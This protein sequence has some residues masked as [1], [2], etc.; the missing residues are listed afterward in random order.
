MAAA[1]TDQSGI[2]YRALFV[3]AEA[4]HLAGDERQALEM[5]EEAAAQAPTAELARRA[6][7]SRLM[8]LTELESDQAAHALQA[9]SSGVPADDPHELVLEA[10]RRLGVELK[11]G[12]LRSLQRARDAAQLVPYVPDVLVRIS[13]R[14]VLAAALTTSSEYLEALR[15]ARDM[16][17]DAEE[18]KLEFALPYAHTVSAAAQAGLR[19]FLAAEREIEKASS[20]AIAISSSHAFFNA[21]AQRIRILCQM[22]RAFEACRVQLPTE[23]AQHAALHAELQASR[24]L[25]LVAAGR[26]DDAVDTL[27]SMR[28]SS[29]CIEARILVPAVDALIVLKRRQSGGRQ[30][31]ARLLDE[32]FESGGLDLLVTAYRSCPELLAVLAHDPEFRERIWPLL[33]RAGDTGLVTDAGVL[34]SIHDPSVVLSKREREIYELVCGGLTNRQVAEILFLSEK[35]VKVH[36]QHIFDKTGIRSRRALAI[37]ASRIKLL[38]AAPTANSGSDLSSSGGSNSEL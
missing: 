10:G 17:R 24:A 14:S 27:D 9:L 22:G 35:T 18:H 6:E 31:I 13:F 28:S 30:G 11:F 20:R 36:L 38:Q 16:I 37:E 21:E 34:K 2:T 26:L 29:R 5:F 19:D 8:C 23:P 7:W 15:V 33:S 4:A 32:A 1:R 25:S 12:S 3:A